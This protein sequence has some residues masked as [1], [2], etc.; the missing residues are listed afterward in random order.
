MQLLALDYWFKRFIV[1]QEIKV[2]HNVNDKKKSLITD[3]NV[4]FIVFKEIKVEH[5]ANVKKKS[6]AFQWIFM[7]NK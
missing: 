4:S 1:F 5:I 7:K 6:R 3:L 2:K